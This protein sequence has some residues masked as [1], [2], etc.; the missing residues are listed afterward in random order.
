MRKFI[1]LSVIIV[2]L[3]GCG[4]KNNMPFEQVFI[5]SLQEN[6]FDLLKNNLPDKEFYKSLGDKMPARSDAEIQKFLE[7][8]NDKLKVAWQNTIFNATQKKI[9]FKK[10]KLKEVFYYDPFRRDQ[11]SEALVVN[12]EYDN[13]V[14]DDLQ[15][16]VSRYKGKTY[17]LGIPNPTRA[18]SMSDTECRATNE[19]KAFLEMEKPDFKNNLEALAGR[20]IK[21]AKEN[22]LD[23]FGENLVYGGSDEMRKWRSPM[24]MNDSLERI[25]ANDFIQKVNQYFEGCSD[26][27]VGEIKT[28]R[29][30]EGVWIVLPFK[31]STKIISFAFLRVNDKL[32]LGDLGS[33]GQ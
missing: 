29:Q 17:L 22:K 5:R 10:L 33:E 7:E 23:A 12:Y 21:L 2:L 25:L 15:F 9:D 14:W 1:S 4:N 28:E 18:L 30:S 32:L 20:L 26:Y 13:K 8:S 27:Q 19:A 16:I 31:C 24:N 3:A 11:Q 6:N